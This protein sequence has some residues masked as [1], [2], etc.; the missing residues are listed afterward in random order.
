MKLTIKYYT[1]NNIYHTVIY[2]CVNI[3]EADEMKAEGFFFDSVESCQ[4][5]P[6][7]LYCKNDSLYLQISLKPW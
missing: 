7:T 3:N 6:Q 4:P 2:K 1:D 5:P